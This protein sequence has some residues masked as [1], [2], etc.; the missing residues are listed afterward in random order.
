MTTTTRHLASIVVQLVLV[1]GIALAYSEYPVTYVRLVTED[2]W[3]EFATFASFLTAAFLFG[4][5][6]ARSGAKSARFWY[7]VLAIG[8]FL[9]AMEEISWGQRIIGL[10]TPGALSAINVQDELNF[11]NIDWLSPRAGTYRFLGAL[12]VLFGFLIPLARRYSTRIAAFINRYSFPLPSLYLAP[13]FIA[14]AYHIGFSPLVKGDEVGELLLGLSLSCMAAEHATTRLRDRGLTSVSLTKLVWVFG[15]A[16]IIWAVMFLVILPV[17]ITSAY[18]GESIPVLNSVISGQDTHAIEY[19]LNKARSVGFGLL[20]IL[21]TLG[22]VLIVFSK[23]KREGTEVRP[24]W[25]HFVRDLAVPLVLV[26]MIVVGIALTL[27][28]GRPEYLRR[29]MFS[30]AEISFPEV[31]LYRQALAISSYL[32]NQGKFPIDDLL[33]LRGRLLAESGQKEEAADL[34]KRAL[35]DK[36]AKQKQESRDPADLREIAE[37]YS[38]L[39][40]SDAAHRY[41]NLALGELESSFENDVSRGNRLAVSLNRGQILEATG[42]YDDAI[43]TYLLA[44]EYADRAEEKLQVQ[45]GVTRCLRNC[46]SGQDDLQLKTWGQIQEMH[47]TAQRDSRDGHWCGLSKGNLHSVENR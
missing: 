9:V 22:M 1:T 40:D 6:C 2:N 17:V 33:V 18:R 35:A 32:T 19:Y 3:G 23:Q 43:I 36:L 27:I 26:G 8:C 13:I 21:I 41:W 11:H 47:A 46:G 5:C 16:L 45:L 25:L 30:M 24:G 29:K 10:K 15:G 7:A 12:C 20:G 37:I 38:W 14:T 44:S 31:G 42:R 28:A 34:L 39:G 4:A